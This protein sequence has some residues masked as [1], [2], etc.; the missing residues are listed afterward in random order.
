MAAD[1][2]GHFSPT[3]RRYY[4]VDFSRALPP[5][6]GSVHDR[7]ALFYR[8][9]RAELVMRSPVPLNPDA[10]SGFRGTSGP[11]DDAAFAAD[12]EDIKTASSTLLVK[13][14]NNNSWKQNFDNFF[15]FSANNV[16]LFGWSLKGS[17]LRSIVNFASLL[18]DCRDYFIFMV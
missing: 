17:P 1:V 14:K 3:D 7:E 2:E 18:T 10:F 13:K 12:N 15:S 8:L 11:D 5:D 16:L 4:L 6:V 9:L